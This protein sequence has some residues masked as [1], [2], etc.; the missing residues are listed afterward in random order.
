VRIGGIVAAA[1]SLY[2]PSSGLQIS[3]SSTFG[4]CIVIGPRSVP[5]MASICIT[6]LVEG[7]VVASACSFSEGAEPPAALVDRSI[8]FD[9]YHVVEAGGR[10]WHSSVVE[11]RILWEGSIQSVFVT[12]GFVLTAGSCCWWLG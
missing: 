7:Q 4:V 3:F 2:D 1:V 10:S 12:G 5:W 8:S 6:S 11:G 9:T